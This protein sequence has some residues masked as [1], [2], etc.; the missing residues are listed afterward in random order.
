MELNGKYY[1]GEAITEEGKYSLYKGNRFSRKC[2]STINFV[3]DKTAPVLEVKDVIDYE[4]NMIK[5][6]CLI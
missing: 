5:K 6:Y 3:I 1:N 2:S 4:W